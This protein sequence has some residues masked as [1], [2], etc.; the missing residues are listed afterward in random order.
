VPEPREPNRRSLNRSK[1]PVHAPWLPRAL[2]GAFLLLAPL[3][4]V[5]AV[6][7]QAVA[8]VDPLPTLTTDK[9]DYAPGETV[10]ISGTNFVAG[11]A[12]DI[13]VIR[14][15]GS[16]VKGDGNFNPDFTYTC[17]GGAADCWDSVTAGADGSLTYDY[18]LDGIAGT[19][20]ARA[21][22]SP[23]N[24]DRSLQPVATVTFT[25]GNV[26]VFYAGPGSPATADVAWAKFLD[27]T[28]CTGSPTT[29]GSVAAD[30][31]GENVDAGNNTDSLQLTAELIGNSGA[32][33]SSWTYSAAD[34]TS[35]VSVSGNVIC[36]LGANTGGRAYTAN[37]VAAPANQ[38]PVADAGPDKVGSEGSSVTFN[39]SCTDANTG[40]TWTA[41]VNWGDS[42]SSSLGAVTCNAPAF[43]VSHTFAEN[44]TYT[45]TLTVTDNTSLSG[46]DSAT[47]TIS[48]VAPAIT[49]TGAT[50]AAEGDTVSY[51]YTFTD[52]GTDTWTHTASCGAGATKSNDVFMPG[53]AKSGSFDCTFP[54]DD[55]SPYAVSITVSDDDGGSDTETK[56]VVVSNVAPVLTAAVSPM[57]TFVNFTVTASGSYSDAGIPD[58][59]T[60]TVDWGDGS[61]DTVIVDNTGNGGGTFSTTHQYATAGSYTVTITVCDDDGGCD[62]ETFPVTVQP[63]LFGL[64]SG[65]TITDSAF[66]IGDSLTVL[67]DFEILKAKDNT[68]IA[69]NPGQFYMH[70]RVQ[71]VTGTAQP[72]HME[73]DWDDN[74]ITQGATPIHC[75]IRPSTGG[76][77]ETPC[78]IIRDDG[79]ASVDF[80][81]VP[82]GATVWVT[83]HLDYKW[84]GS[85]DPNV[86]PK[87]FSFT[88]TWTVGPLAGTHTATLVGYAKKTTV[89]YG[90]V[91]DPSGMPIAGAQVSI[92]RNGVT[93]TYTTGSDGFYVFFAGQTCT[94]D[95]VVCTG[96]TSPLTLPNATYTLTIDPLTGYGPTSS[97]CG[98]TTATVT[99]N[100]QGK[101]FRKDVKLYANGLC[102]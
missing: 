39:F 69:T 41:T 88:T 91:L 55:G 5:G 77:S 85:Q 27:Q 40:N 65:T 29:S 96:G 20:E 62:V 11:L 44:G 1:R 60:V 67:L 32:V 46:S 74:F 95:G 22:L 24:G 78:T 37:Y 54:D 23:W 15:D 94:G 9:A 59:H 30:T 100:A 98:N 71:N 47:A 87:S 48:N 73:L 3:L 21:Y 12:Y 49:F 17:P 83:I 102:P 81:S 56:S 4:A 51:S 82:A 28:T 99:V 25:D 14:P 35:V 89:I 18:I 2:A 6:S 33:F 92:I 50:T 75:Y 43:D 79:K 45:V 10:H 70:G 93:Y 38:P 68:V 53:G 63:G 90:Y 19:Y 42:T 80:A 34:G 84:K 16:I 61:T 86:T 26:K 8:A 66:Q 58:T 13:P 97:T 52:P 7:P 36:V 64:S 31:N 57:N 101:A 76:W 72:V